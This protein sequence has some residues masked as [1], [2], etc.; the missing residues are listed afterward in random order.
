MWWAGKELLKGKTLGDYVGKNE[1]TK[2]VAKLQ[3]SGGGPPVREPAIDPDSYKNMLSYYKKK[4][5]EM[6][7]ILFEKLAKK[8]EI[9][10]R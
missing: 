8:L 10:R 7:V 1:K 5:D 3:K 2:I 6:K 4:E 9:G